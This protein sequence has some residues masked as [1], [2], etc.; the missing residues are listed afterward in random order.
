MGDWNVCYFDKYFSFMSYKS[1]SRFGLF[2]VNAHFPTLPFLN[3]FGLLLVI[4]GGIAF[5]RIR[6]NV[7]TVTIDNDLSIEENVLPREDTEE[8]SSLLNHDMSIAVGCRNKRIF[9][10]FAALVAGVF[11][12]ITFVPVI[13]MQDHPDM[14][15]GTSRNGL[16]YV[17]SHYCG[18]FI[19]ATLLF[20]LY[21][22]YSNN[23]PAVN[24]HII[25]PSLMAGCMWG[26]AQSS[27][28]VANDNLSQS[29]TFP[30][31]TML[32]GVGAAL[33]SVFYFRE[34]SGP[35]N[36]CTLVVATLT[37]LTGAILVGVSK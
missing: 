32:P 34:I 8:S 35:S 14:F 36:L 1:I 19:T 37:T 10:I 18:I 21:I 15:P 5:S 4:I 20:A 3:Y 9:A 33:W 28:F 6:P 7:D 16:T 27:W 29:V 2:G 22:V 17:F 12:G 30:I 31:I 13:Y 25:G 11:Y 26:I 23:R 24:S